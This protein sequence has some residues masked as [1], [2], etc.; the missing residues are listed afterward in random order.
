MKSSWRVE[1]LSLGHLW[2]FCP[3]IAPGPCEKIDFLLYQSVHFGPGA[4]NPPISES[5]TK[6]W[7]EFS[8]DSSPKVHAPF[9]FPQHSVQQG[10]LRKPRAPHRPTCLEGLEAEG[11]AGRGPSPSSTEFATGNPCTLPVCHWE[12]LHQLFSWFCGTKSNLGQ[13]VHHNSSPQ[14]RRLSG[15][16]FPEILP[17]LAK[18]LM[19]KLVR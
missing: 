12:A 9:P 1:R 10:Q 3:Y 17:V 6:T 4:W 13:C 19:K 14:N 7:V 8:N 2:A 18:E 11:R 16:C 15:A 5:H